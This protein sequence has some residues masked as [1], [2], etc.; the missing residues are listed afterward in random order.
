[1]LPFTV[2]LQDAG[3]GRA[4]LTFDHTDSNYLLMASMMT[5]GETNPH[6]R[7]LGKHSLITD[8]WIFRIHGGVSGICSEIYGIVVCVGV[9]AGKHVRLGVWACFLLGVGHHPPHGH[10][11]PS[12]ILVGDHPGSWK[13]LAPSPLKAGMVFVCELM[14]ILYPLCT[15][16]HNTC[17]FSKHQPKGTPASSQ[18]S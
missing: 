4:T 17:L 10:S 13:A 6:Q 18:V 7:I 12:S 11:L 14:G 9:R 15:Q 8:R 16:P 1:M 2:C 3:A 5:C